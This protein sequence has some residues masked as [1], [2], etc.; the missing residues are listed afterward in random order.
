[1]YKEVYPL[2]IRQGHT[3]DGLCVLMLYDPDGNRNVPMMIGEHE[4]EM[5]ILEREGSK[6]RRPMTHELIER[7]FDTFSLELKEV[8]IDSFK[9]G[10][11]YATLH[12]SDGIQTQRIDSR[13]SDA[14]VLALREEVAIKMDTNVLEET[15][16]PADK[17]EDSTFGNT[18][19]D[20]EELGL[21]ALQALLQEYENNEEYEK[22]A[23]LAKKIEKIQNN[24]N[25]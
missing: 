2:E 12:I 6:T 4:A 14:I 16:Y 17:D 19:P 13:A 5:I 22:A 10:I 25:D 1:M 7:I 15:G 20:E 8:T 21:E 24:K 11:F 9:E 23:E 18:R 3:L